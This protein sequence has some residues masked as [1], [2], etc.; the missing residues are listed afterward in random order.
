MRNSFSRYAEIEAEE[1]ERLGSSKPIVAKAVAER[2]LSED[3]N[4]EDR[5]WEQFN[6]LKEFIEL[7]E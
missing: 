6:A 7:L 5:G 1:I 4:P 3:I 2:I